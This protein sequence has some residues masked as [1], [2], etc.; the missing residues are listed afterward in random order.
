MENKTVSKKVPIIVAI[1]WLVF[2]AMSHAVTM[3]Y[4]ILEL[5]TYVRLVNASWP[6]MLLTV[7][8]CGISALFMTAITV[9][10]KKA[11]IKWL[12]IV[13]MIHLFVDMGICLL[14]AMPLFFFY[15]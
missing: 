5:E 9:L 12:Q 1:A 11:Q 6:I 15:L 4:S 14:S 3:G 8:F 10:A 13:S 2:V 7:I